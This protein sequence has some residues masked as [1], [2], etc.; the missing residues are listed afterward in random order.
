MEKTI[1]ESAYPLSFRQ[2]E[3]A[4]LAT[5]L[6]SRHS[7]SLI[8]MKR[9]GI[10]NFLRFFLYNKEITKTYLSE[11]KHLFIPVDL[12]DLVEREIYPFWRLTFKRIV[13]AVNKSDITDTIKKDVERS[14]LE[15]IQTQD[16]FVAID[17]VRHTLVTL[18]ENGVFPTLF[19]LRFDR[20][21]DSV[22]PEFFSNLQGLKDATHQKLSY[23]FTSF[24]SLDIL[25]PKVFSRASL[26]VFTNNMYI[27]P[28]S[29][30]DTKIIYNTYKTRY[31]LSLGETLEH[32]LFDTV[33]GYVQYLQ[34][35]LISLHEAKESVQTKE[36][37][38]ERL[39]KDERISLQSEE[40]WES[41]TPDEQKVLVKIA[42][43]TQISPE[44]REKAR[45][46]WDTGFIV[47]N[48]VFSPLFDYYLK[49][50]QGMAENSVVEFT[51]K[52]NA[53]FS[54]LKQHV[55]EIC[56]REK[57]VESVWPEV[58]ALGVSDWAI[59]RLVARVRSKL[60]LQKKGLEIQTIKTRGY[61]L[62]SS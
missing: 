56:E 40:L 30:E 11:D 37:L 34:L 41:L 7:V 29:R 54:V 53:L 33:D 8:G 6:K 15:S 9:V 45:Y 61:K 22:T 32:V 13:D 25:S 48:T 19:L 26:S 57:I 24:R 38:V 35:A 23:V 55:N 3:A 52:E 36:Q 43:G 1:I 39:S 4:Q 20:I 10:S 27:K 47:E 59:D 50:K 62:I 60:K 21:K 12:N 49:A 5:H 17:N 31:K 16:L 42:K 28:A 14:F 51:K 46:L 58:E 44:E 2:D 18:V